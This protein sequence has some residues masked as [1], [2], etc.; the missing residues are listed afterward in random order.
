[1]K[2]KRILISSYNLDF[3]G[4]ETSLINLLKRFDY[5]KYDVT[6]VLE[7]REGA[8]LEEIPS[9]VKILEYSVSVSNNIFVRKLINMFKRIKWSIFNFKRFDASISYATYS[10]PCSFLARSASSNSILFV[11]GDYYLG[12]KKD[13]VR[14]RE[15]FKSVKHSSFKKMVFVSNESKDSFINVCG[16]RENLYVINNLIDYKRVIKLSKVKDAVPEKRSTTF[17]YLGRLDEEQKKLSYLLSVALLCKSNKIKCDFW[18]VGSGPYE[19]KCKDFIKNN[20]LDNV[21]LLGSKKNPYPYIA[22]ADYLIL[23]SLY[24][25][26]PV[27]Y[28]EAI[29]LNKHILTTVD[30]SDD[31]IKI[32]EGFGT[33]ASCDVNSI[34]E[35]VVLLSNKVISNKR[36]VNFEKLNHNRI[37]K[38]E[39]LLEENKSL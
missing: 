34:Y 39:E 9:N 15:F 23:T 32:S 16:F 19:E 12:F 14:T 36:K 38:I 17:L 31:F 20:K 18:I 24:E 30:V 26:F 4:I 10:K 13:E 29:I 7:K 27:V 6:L 21:K 5:E 22:S 28:N 11:H 1:M 8:F 33:I 25:G 2:R 35:K 3:G 37:R